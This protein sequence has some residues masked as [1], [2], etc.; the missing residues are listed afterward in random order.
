MSDMSVEDFVPLVVPVAGTAHAESEAS[1]DDFVE[2]FETPLVVLEFGKHPH[3]DLFFHELLA[4]PGHELPRMHVETLWAVPGAVVSADMLVH[5]GHPIVRFVIDAG[6]IPSSGPAER[7]TFTLCAECEG[8]FFHQLTQGEHLA[9][10]AS[11]PDDVSPDDP[12]RG[13]PELL[14]CDIDAMDVAEAE[15]WAWRAAYSMNIA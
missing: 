11:L 1:G 13:T 3:E 10:V 15:L 2:Q 4:A 7:L 6:P 12:L 14:L 8:P 5:D 9:V